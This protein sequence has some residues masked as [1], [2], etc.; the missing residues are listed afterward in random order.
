MIATG[1]GEVTMRSVEERG[2]SNDSLPRLDQKRR[3]LDL[4]EPRCYFVSNV[5]R[6]AKTCTEVCASAKAGK[7]CKSLCG[8]FSTSKTQLAEF[9][10]GGLE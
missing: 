6:G 4:F 9:V 2:G 5:K 7:A 10:K 8:R 3:K 1:Q